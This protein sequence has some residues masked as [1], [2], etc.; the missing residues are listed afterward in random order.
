MNAGAISWRSH[1][2]H[3]SNHVSKAVPL[4]PCRRQ[5]GEK[6]SSYSFLTSAL[7][8][9]S[10]QSHA[11]DALSPQKRT[12]GS[13]WT[14]GWVGLR[15]GLDTEARTKILCFCPGS[16]PGVPASSQSLYWLKYPS[17]SSKP[18]RTHTLSSISR[19][20]RCSAVETVSLNNVRINRAINVFWYTLGGVGRYILF[21]EQIFF[22]KCL[23]CDHVTH[24]CWHS[25]TA[26]GLRICCL[27]VSD[28]KT[29]DFMML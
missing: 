23:I 4:P 2:P 26:V 19:R 25:F 5:R 9:V 11:P 10:G 13:H 18:I 3:P 22:P 16:N 21:G 17:F 8:G 27:D 28:C 7:E 14:G 12:P 20:S 24:V 6:Y 29:L 1:R 15:A